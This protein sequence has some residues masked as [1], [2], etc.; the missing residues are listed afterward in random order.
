[1]IKR[2]L[3]AVSALLLCVGAEGK[4]DEFEYVKSHLMPPFHVADMGRPSG[5]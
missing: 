4:G 5:R 3:I 1:M 2:V